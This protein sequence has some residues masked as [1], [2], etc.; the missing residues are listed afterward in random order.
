[1]ETHG[2]I[3]ILRSYGNLQ[4]F[5]TSTNLWKLTVVLDFEKNNF[6]KLQRLKLLQLVTKSE[7]TVVVG[8]VY[9][10]TK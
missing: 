1:M 8:T 9:I 2:R 7:P 10:Y 3:E 6:M 4:S 5:W